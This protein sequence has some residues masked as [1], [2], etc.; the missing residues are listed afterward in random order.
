MRNFAFSFWW[1]WT[2]MAGELKADSRKDFL[3]VRNEDTRWWGWC[4][5]GSAQVAG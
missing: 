3:S 2:A 4:R 5:E 1:E